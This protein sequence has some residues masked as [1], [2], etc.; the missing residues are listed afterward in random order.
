MIPHQPT[1]SR[2]LI[3]PSHQTLGGSVKS[4]LLITDF[5]IPLVLLSFDTRWCLARNSAIARSWMTAHP[6]RTR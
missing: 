6:Y 4:Q 3:V 5:R 2:N 1:P